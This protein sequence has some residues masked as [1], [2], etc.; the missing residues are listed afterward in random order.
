MSDEQKELRRKDSS[1]RIWVNNSETKE[2]HFIRRE[3][4]KKYEEQGYVVG[5]I[6][7]WSSNKG[8]KLE[9][10]DEQRKRRSESHKGERNAMY[11]KKLRDF[12]SEEEYAN[13]RNA[14]KGKPAW[15]K[16][17]KKGHRQ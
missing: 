16:G 11:G 9:L 3:E 1:N 4:L 17:M 8:K 2:C 7:W 14:R 15:N 12:M 10:T 13:W 5:R 6:V